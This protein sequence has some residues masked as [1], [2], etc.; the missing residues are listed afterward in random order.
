MTLALALVE[1]IGGSV[2]EI[3]III[4]IFL[5]KVVVSCDSLISQSFLTKPRDTPPPTNG[6][7]CRYPTEGYHET[8]NEQPRLTI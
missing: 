4:L 3:I 8:Y 6:Y 1:S 7:W 2:D 5:I